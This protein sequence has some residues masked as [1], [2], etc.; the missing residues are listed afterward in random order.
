MHFLVA[1]AAGRGQ[2]VVLHLKSD[3]LYV[4]KI[5]TSF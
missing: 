5:G 3:I 1:D 2:P 4:S